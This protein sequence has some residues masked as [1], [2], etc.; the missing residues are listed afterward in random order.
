[1][2]P[3]SLWPFSRLIYFFVCLQFSSSLSLKRHNLPHSMRFIGLLLLV[4]IF[5]VSGY[6]KITAPDAAALKL[7]K[8]S[9]PYLF[10]E[11]LKLATL[12]YKL[13][14]ADY[15]LLIRA[16]GGIFVAFSAFIVLNIGRRFFSFLLALFLAFITVSMHLTLP[17]VDA[18]PMDEQV[19]VLKNLAIIGGLL[20]VAGSGGARRAATTVE[21]AAKNKKKQ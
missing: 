21:T 11:A 1:M 10:N 3:L 16:T 14:A 5:A 13:T 15:V 2:C 12:K 6:F 19:Q 7:S 17:K 9:F 20:F 4:A 18:T 8:S